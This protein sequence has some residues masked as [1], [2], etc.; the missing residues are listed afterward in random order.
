M[1][2]IPAIGLTSAPTD[3]GEVI[4]SIRSQIPD[5]VANPQ[6]D[7]GAFS[8]DTLRRWI[9]DSMRIMATASPVVEDWYGI[10]S[11]QGMD[12]YELP[13]ETL[14]V[15]QLWYDLLP[16]VRAPEAL[17][18]YVNKIQSRGYYFGPH[19][20]HAQQRLQVWPASDR[21]ASTTTLTANISATDRTI[22]VASASA[23][24][25]MGF[26]SIDDEIILYRTI[27]AAGTSITQ[28]LRGQA[29]TLP[30]AHTSGVTVQ[31]RNIMMK[32]SRLPVAIV[33]ATDPIEIPN[34][35]LPLIELYVLA[36]VREAEQES[37]IAMAMRKEWDE[38]MRKLTSSSQLA[39][40]KQGLQ[41]SS[42]VGPDLYRGRVFIP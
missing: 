8:Y 22:P 23:F 27:N 2:P 30:A 25:A 29:G 7:G 5:P 11:E 13:T 34:G 36:K 28:T 4:L 12:I 16:C 39:G 18:I 6:D 20:T 14:S 3:A 31:E 1:S 26:L 37:Q 38:A 33:N 10:P 24:K 41:V 42:A 32:M 21:S 15:E 40:I 19:S 35:L 17:T 9:N